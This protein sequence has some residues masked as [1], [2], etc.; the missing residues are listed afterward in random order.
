MKWRGK[1]IGGSFGSI[2]GPT[3]A[4]IGAA[5]G[6]Y[7]VDRKGRV[8]KKDRERI[9]VL[10]AGALHQITQANN[11]FTHLTDQAFRGILEQAN[12]ALD[13]VMSH[14]DLLYLIAQSTHIPGCLGKLAPAVRPYPELSR[15][16]ATWFWRIAA[17]DAPPSPA[18]L[19]M[20]ERFGHSAGLTPEQILQASLLYYRG[21]FAIAQS[22]GE[23]EKACALLGV[24]YNAGNDEIKQAFRRMS[25][26]Y[27]PDKHTGLDPDIRKLTAERFSQIKDAYELL[28]NRSD[29]GGEWFA[30]SCQAPH[31]VRAAPGM[32]VSCY[33]CRTPQ[34]LPQAADMISEAHCPLCQA[35][36]VF[37]KPLAEHLLAQQTGGF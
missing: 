1:A 36:L 31:I 25:L 18:A 28:Q 17:C 7:L 37:E 15:A 3:G 16:A 27:H 10:T 13:N 6:H 12:T 21:A 5:A 29:D 4:L 9:L 24:A 14:Y 30:H 19:N 26:K 20:L 8:S 32:P 22:N 33:I 11:R 35:L 23:R 2:F 34:H